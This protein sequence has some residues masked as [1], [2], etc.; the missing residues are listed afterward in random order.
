MKC[1]CPM[2]GDRTCP[3]DCDYVKWTNLNPAEKK[4][5]RKKFAEKDYRAGYTMEQIATKL[6]VRHTTIVSDLRDLS[7]PDKSK[8]EKKTAT[9]P[10]GSGR[11]KGSKKPRQVNPG[12]RDPKVTPAKEEALAKAVLDEGK[13]VAKAASDL[14]LKHSNARM[15][16]AREQGR[17]EAEAEPKIATE[18][19]SLSAQQRLDAAVRQHKR[20]LDVEFEKRVLDEVKRRID[21]IVLPH[22]KKQ[23]KE[24]EQLYARRRGLMD[25]E[26]FNTIRRAL[27]PDSRNSISDRKLGEAFDAFM[28]LEKLLLNEK[29]SPT[30]IGG[31]PDSLAEW[32]KMKAQARAARSTR[33]GTDGMS[34]R[35][36]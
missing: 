2:G 32:D 6:G 22:W 11:P 1:V 12:R 31:L 33:R 20:S 13:P 28:G 35:T 23:I 24:A 9:N 14:G 30:T 19:L 7:V 10:K 36:R 5:Q 27:H 18:T 34:V 15:L 4:A 21:E 26:T 16:I 25:K 8:D 29:D 17:R 3:D